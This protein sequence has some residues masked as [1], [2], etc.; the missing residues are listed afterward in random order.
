MVWRV[1]DPQGNESGKIKWEIVEFTR[2]RVLDIGASNHKPF[3]HFIGVDNNK[4]AALFGILCKPDLCMDADNLELIKDAS[5][6]AVYSS[7]TLEHMEEPKK[8]L[9]EGWRVM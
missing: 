3:Q 7:H 9:K 5:M 4:D 8:V 6:D 2:G 1:E